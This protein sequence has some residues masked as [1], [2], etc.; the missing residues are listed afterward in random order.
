MTAWIMPL[1]GISWNFAAGLLVAAAECS[2]REHAS[3]AAAANQPE[4][5]G[6]D[7]PP[8]PRLIT[9]PTPD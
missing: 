2:I 7:E 5:E 6:I 1:G 9:L 4:F 3:A 8:Q